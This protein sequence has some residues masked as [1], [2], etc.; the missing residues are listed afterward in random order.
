MGRDLADNGLLGF[1][2][3]W[4]RTFTSTFQ[5]NVLPLPKSRCQPIIQHVIIIQK[6]II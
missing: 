1:D 3:V 5:T 2:T 4:D 6:T